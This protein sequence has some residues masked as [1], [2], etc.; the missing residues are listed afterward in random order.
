MITLTVGNSLVTRATVS[1]PFSPG[2]ATV[3][4][5]IKEAI[6]AGELPFSLLFA[7]SPLPLRQ[8]AAEKPRREC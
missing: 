3:V 7:D 2:I 1:K 5:V 4:N 8:A 6:Q